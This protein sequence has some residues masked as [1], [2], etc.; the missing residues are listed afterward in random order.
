M[1]PPYALKRWSFWNAKRW[2][3]SEA[4]DA[5]AA[6]AAAPTKPGRQP[7]WQFQQGSLTLRALLGRCLAENERRMVPY[8][9][10]LLRPRLVPTI[11]RLLY[12][13]LPASI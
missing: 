10:R 4:A 7:G 12:R 3:G 11:A 9:P 8:D 5:A 6:G 2:T 13:L 1:K